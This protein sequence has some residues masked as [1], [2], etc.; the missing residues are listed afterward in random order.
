VDDI[1]V[2]GSEVESLK[3][4]VDLSRGRGASMLKDSRLGE[5]RRFVREKN[6]GMTYVDLKATSRLIKGLTSQGALG[7][8]EKGRGQVV[9]DLRDFLQILETL[10]YSWSAAQFERDYV[11]ITFYVAL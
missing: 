10:N 2:I 9:K 4:M 11:R 1:L 8:F 6:N 3:R 7:G 5:M